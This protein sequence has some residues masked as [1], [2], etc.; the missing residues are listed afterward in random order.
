LPVALLALPVIWH[1]LPHIVHHNDDNRSIDWLGA[2]LL[3]ISICGLLFATEQGQTNGFTPGTIGMGCIAVACGAAFVWHQ[4]HTQAPIIPP[5]LLDNPG[6]RKLMALGILTGMTM[7]MLIFYAPLLLQGGFGQS[8]KQAGLV[9]TPLLV[10][11]TL[12]SIT[13]G[14]ILPYLKRAERVIA[15]GQ[16]GTFASCIL[17]TALVPELPQTLAMLAFALCG[18]SLGFQLPNLTLQ[19]QAA[20]GKNSLG[21]G[22]ALI[23]TTRMLGSMI[24]VA[25]A[26]LLVNTA[27]AQRIVLELAAKHINEP[28]V[29]TLLSSPQVLVRQEDQAQLL[30]LAHAQGLDAMPLLAAAREGLIHGIHTTFLAGALVAGVS[31]FISLRLP[32]YE[33]VKNR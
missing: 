1:Y 15:W 9:M 24:G 14:R 30:A 13:N 6:A 2:L 28:D 32:R 16:L 3:A 5:S 33:L 18:A 23:Q 7:F 26:G 8:P 29:V 12:G 10:C 20:A 31:I 19:M 22:S 25:F 27:Y 11:V 4:Y 21:V 17:L